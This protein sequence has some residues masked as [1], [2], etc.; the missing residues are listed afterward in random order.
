MGGP[1]QWEGAGPGE[2]DEEVYTVQDWNNNGAKKHLAKVTERNVKICQKMVRPA[3]L[4]VDWKA[5]Y[6]RP[7]R[8][9][10][11]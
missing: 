6:F 5:R 1:N 10:D 2:I 4:H 11:R 3:T 9:V 7:C 8:Y